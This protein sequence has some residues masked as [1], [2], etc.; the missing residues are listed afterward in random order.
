MNDESSVVSPSS[1]PVHIKLW[2]PG[3]ISV[4]TFLFGFPGS[5]V[6]ASINWLRMERKQKAISYMILCGLAMITVVLMGITQPTGSF[7]LYSFLL[8]IGMLMYLYNETLADINK[9]KASGH[10]VENASWVGGLLISLGMMVVRFLMSA[11]AALIY[12]I[13]YAPITGRTW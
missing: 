2:A 8:N 4:L 1:D 5:M 3:L 10:I 9:L 12:A 11:L 13:L 7:R 6:L